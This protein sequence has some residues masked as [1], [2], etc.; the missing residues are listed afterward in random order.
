MELSAR[1]G[2]SGKVVEIITGAVTS[3]VRLD[4]KDTFVTSSITNDAVSELELPVR[5]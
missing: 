4:V 1:N 2:L 3:H 5:D